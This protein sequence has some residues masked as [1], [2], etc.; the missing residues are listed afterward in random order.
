MAEDKFLPHLPRHTIIFLSLLD[1]LP[2]LWPRGLKKAAELP[3]ITTFKK[4]EL[5]PGLVT[6]TFNPSIEE[7]EAGRSLWVQGQCL[8]TMSSKTARAT[9]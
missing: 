1:S 2:L 4:Q 5:L 7:A 9:W 3:D 8:L 6:H